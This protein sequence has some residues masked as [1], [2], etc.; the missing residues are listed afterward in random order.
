MQPYH[1]YLP[2]SE[3]SK[4]SRVIMWNQIILN[5]LLF[6]DPSLNSSFMLFSPSSPIQ[7]NTSGYG[8]ESF[9]VFLCLVFSVGSLVRTNINLCMHLGL[10]LISHFFISYAQNLIDFARYNISVSSIPDTR[11]SSINIAV[12]QCCYLYIEISKTKPRQVYW[13]IP[14]H[15]PMY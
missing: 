1:Y 15:Y 13:Q 9:S 11:Y 3:N 10:F 8:N 14:L 12:N 7:I 5:T 4:Y 6:S 2:F